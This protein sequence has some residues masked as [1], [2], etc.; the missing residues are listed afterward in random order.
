MLLLS[1]KCFNHEVVT[2]WHPVRVEGF[3]T[4]G[5]TP[6]KDWFFTWGR[7]E[8]IISPVKAACFVPH[9]TNEDIYDAHPEDRRHEYRSP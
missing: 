3:P 4:Y 5:I 2:L 1:V 7:F 6:E 9:N 8:G